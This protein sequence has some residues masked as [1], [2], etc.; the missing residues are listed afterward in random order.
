M[1]VRSADFDRQVIKLSFKVPRLTL[2]G[3]YDVRGKILGM[4]MYGDGEYKMVFS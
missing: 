3:W 1:C 2:S 4:P